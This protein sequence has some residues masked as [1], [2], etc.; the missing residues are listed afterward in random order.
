MVKA[1]FLAGNNMLIVRNWGISR[2]RYWGAPHSD[3]A[4]AAGSCRCR[5]PGAGGS[6]RDPEAGSA[7]LPLHQRP[8]FI[9]ASCQK[10]GGPA[11]RETDTMDTFMESSW[12]LPVLPAHATILNRSPKNRPPIGCRSINISAES[13]MPSSTCSIHVFHQGP[14]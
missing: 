7:C 8:S 5:S 11:R 10:C 3:A 2:Q 4:R 9:A 12:Y 1:S 6:P 13:S 14:P